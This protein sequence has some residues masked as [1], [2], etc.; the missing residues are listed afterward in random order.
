LEANLH[1]EPSKI[2]K[3]KPFLL[4]QDFSNVFLLAIINKYITPIIYYCKS[5]LLFY[6]NF[7]KIW[8]SKISKILFL[9]EKNKKWAGELLLEIMLLRI[10]L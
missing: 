10:S 9:C 8:L 3:N 6:A 2:S 4:S 1:I 7:L 5:S